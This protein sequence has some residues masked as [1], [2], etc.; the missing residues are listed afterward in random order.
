MKAQFSDM[1]Q[2][3]VEF[4]ANSGVHGVT[5][6]Q[7][8]QRFQVRTA[9]LELLLTPLLLEKKIKQ[10]MD[11]KRRAIG[12]PAMRFFAPDVELELIPNEKPA[13]PILP[14]GAPPAR[15][16]PCQ[17]CGV[18]IPMPEVGRPHVYCSETC[19]RAS[20]DGGPE[21]KDLL[22]RASDPRT[23]ARVGLCL[24]M[25]DL[26]IRGFQIATDLFGATSRLIVHDGAGVAFLDVFMLPD[27]GYFPPPDDYN[28]VALVYRDGRIAYAGRQPLIESEAAPSQHACEEEKHAD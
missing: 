28:S 17:V 9:D 16:S 26:S 24:V 2:R 1:K 7:L 13:M 18:A 12:R 15:S 20:R 10:Q 3:V 27:S 25:A 19:R 14:F 11:P 22:A 6:T 5:R 8:M 23:R 4:I 21:V